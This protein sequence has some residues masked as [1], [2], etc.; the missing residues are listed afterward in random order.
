MNRSHN[1]ALLRGLERIGRAHCHDRV[2]FFE[3]L[4]I[5]VCFTVPFTSLSI[6]IGGSNLGSRRKKAQMNPNDAAYHLDFA[7][8]LLSRVPIKPERA[9]EA[10][11]EA[12]IALELLPSEDILLDGDGQMRALAHLIL[13][14]ALCECGELDAAATNWRRAVELDPVKPPFGVSGI[15]AERLATRGFP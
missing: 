13:G 7:A 6:H 9:K 12:C 11:D 10:K 15:A 8:F 5:E 14:D 2:T 1:P 3:S 4:P